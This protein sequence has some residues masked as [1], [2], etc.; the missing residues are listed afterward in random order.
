MG[1]G[2]LCFK[3]GEEG[4]IARDCQSEQFGGNG[5]GMLRDRQSGP[6]RDDWAQQLRD[7]E[8]G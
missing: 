4:H 2:R 6:L 7:D 3:C 8:A 5:R 1:A